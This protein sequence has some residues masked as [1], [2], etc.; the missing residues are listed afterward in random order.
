MSQLLETISTQGCCLGYIYYVH[1]ML[2]CY[3]MTNLITQHCCHVS[4]A[5]FG[6][7]DHILYQHWHFAT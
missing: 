3:R 7:P 4:V 6:R 2:Q 5:S 1:I